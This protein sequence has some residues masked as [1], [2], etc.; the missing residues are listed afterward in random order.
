MFDI[1]HY[2]FLRLGDFRPLHLRQIVRS[3]AVQIVTEKSRGNTP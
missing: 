3:M 2:T 1:Q